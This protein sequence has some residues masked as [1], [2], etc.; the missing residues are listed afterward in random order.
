MLA[1]MARRVALVTGASRGIGRA[2]AVELA[3]RGHVVAVNYRK[4]DEEARS[5]VAS[6][7][8]NGGEAEA[9]KADVSK[10]DEVDRMFESIEAALGR[11]DILV[12]NAGWGLISPLTQMTHE[13]WERHLKVNLGGAYLC[14][15]RALPGM[16]GKG[17]GRII[18]VSSVAGIQGLAGL[19]AYSTAK[20]GLIGFT[21]ALAQELRGSGVTV[22]AIAPGFVR[23]DMGVSFFK[24]F[25]EDPDQWA[26]RETLTGKLVEPEE[27]ARVVSFLASD[28]ASNITGQVFIIDSGLSIAGGGLYRFASRL[29][30]LGK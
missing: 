18:N 15:R 1:L 28:S 13:L 19:V 26:S 12:N 23:T 4:R 27:V 5:T 21:K 8:S 17:W 20:A 24:F 30:E 14:T 7:R 29:Q 25:G 6:I 9:F 22:N 10:P 2:I 16:L 11:V 3:R